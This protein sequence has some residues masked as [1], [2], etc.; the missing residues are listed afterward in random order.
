MSR[1]LAGRPVDDRQDRQRRRARD[2]RPP[3]AR[4][5]RLL[6][7]LARQGRPRRRRAVRHRPDRCHRH[8]RR[9]RAARARARLRL[10]HGLPAELRPPRA[11]PRVRRQRRVDDVHARRAPA[12]AR[13]PTRRSA[14][15]ACGAA[16]RSTPSGIY[17]GHAP[18]V[19]LAASAMCS[20]IERLSILE[21]LDI[22][23]YANEQMFR[24]QGFDLEPDD[25]AAPQACE[26]SCGSFKDQIAGDREGAG[27]RASTASGSGSSSPPRTQDTDFGFMTAAEG[28]DRR[29]QGH[30][31]GRQGRPVAHRVQLRLEARRGHDAE[32]AGHPRLRHRARRR[33]RASA[34]ASSPRASTSTGPSRRPC[35][36]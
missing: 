33:S 19:A 10:V 18:M 8:R 20:R 5:R 21:S 2:G 4:P 32:L 22:K 17:P 15:P 25:P 16:P 29:V 26:S 31:L 23:G 35:R 36:S 24:A 6:R 14:T 7:L 12:T 13:R 28:P 34:S 27:R 30:G 11:H 1:T 9:R 3:G